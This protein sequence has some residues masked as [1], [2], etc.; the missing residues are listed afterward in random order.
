MKD[1][2]DAYTLSSPYLITIEWYSEFSKQQDGTKSFSQSVL[3]FYSL[4]HVRYLSLLPPG[5]NVYGPVEKVGATSGLS[6]LSVAY[7]ITT[8]ANWTKR[9]GIAVF[10]LPGCSRKSSDNTLLFFPS[11][12]FRDPSSFAMLLLSASTPLFLFGCAAFY[13]RA[14]VNFGLQMGR[15]V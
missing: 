6:N 10:L 11:I 7:S 3:M 9:M 2:W 14:R 13:Q 15:N 12:R 8:K 1:I 5:F 4:L